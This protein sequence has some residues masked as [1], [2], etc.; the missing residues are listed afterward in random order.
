MQVALPSARDDFPTEVVPGGQLAGVMSKAEPRKDLRDT[1][2][3]HP[4]PV[5]HFV[6]VGALRHT[7]SEQG[8]SQVREPGLGVP[9]L[10]W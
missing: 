10:R 1:V 8:M 5:V 4:R 6:A 2:F 3:D 9:K 7:L